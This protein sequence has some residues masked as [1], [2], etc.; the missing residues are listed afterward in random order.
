MYRL[1]S[2]L[3]RRRLLVGLGV[4]A[5]A[6]LCAHP[7][8]ASDF[9]GAGS[10]FSSFGNYLGDVGNFL[11]SPMA[12]FVGALAIIGG[13]ITYIRSGE[14]NQ[15]MHIFGGVAIGIGALIIAISLISSVGSGVVI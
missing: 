3:T 5:V 14:L 6:A 7:A 13:V 12:K 2:G 4:F 8:L 9:N 11:M 10:G 15:S 1:L